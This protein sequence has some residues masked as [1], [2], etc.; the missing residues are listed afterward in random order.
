[1]RIEIPDLEFSQWYRWEQREEYPL[2]RF[3]GVYLISITEREDLH[4]QLP[5]YKDV[6]YIGRTL[7]QKGLA[8][9]W[10]QFF[11]TLKGKRGHSG[12]KTIRKELGTYDTW[13]NK[14]MYASGLGIS[15]NLVT[16][17]SADYRL[18]AAVVYL[19]YEAFAR[20]YEIVGGHPRFN[21]Q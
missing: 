5:D 2:A 9:R 4:G 20:Y 7:S 3:P 8:N 1:M 11:Q 16:P 17:T 10:Y 18:M 21:T 19:E 14:H 15:C 12:A 13:R 6:V